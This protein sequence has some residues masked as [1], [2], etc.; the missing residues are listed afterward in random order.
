[1]VDLWFVVLICHDGV[2]LEKCIF[3]KVGLYVFLVMMTKRD[4][5]LDM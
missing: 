4:V 3:G 2:V 5:D 1:M